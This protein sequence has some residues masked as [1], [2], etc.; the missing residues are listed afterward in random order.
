MG[1]YGAFSSQF[2]KVKKSQLT[3]YFEFVGD[4]S[5]GQGKLTIQL[6]QGHT[7]RPEGYGAEQNE[8][9]AVPEQAEDGDPP[10]PVGPGCQPF[11]VILSYDASAGRGSIR[12]EGMDEEVSF[13]RGVLPPIFRKKRPVPDLVGVDVSVEISTNTSNGP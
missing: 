5:S 11:G 12:C 2:K 10:I 8:L 13:T 7:L 4:V 9:D 3:D 1:D 6:P